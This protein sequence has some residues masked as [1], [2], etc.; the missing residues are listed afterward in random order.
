ML[1]FVVLPLVVA[2]AVVALRRPLDVLLPAY[3][4]TVPFGAALG[5]G[6]QLPL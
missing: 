4:V 1:A 2:C 5:P 6:S 3:A